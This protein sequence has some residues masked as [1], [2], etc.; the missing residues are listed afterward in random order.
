MRA[1]EYFQGILFLTT[2]RVE[3]FDPAFKSRIHLGLF[4][5]PLNA[6]SRR[7][8]WKNLLSRPEIKRDPLLLDSDLSSL[9]DGSGLNGRQIKNAVQIANAL[10]VGDGDPVSR[11][12]L[13]LAIGT[14]NAFDTEVD[15]STGKKPDEDPGDESDAASAMPARKRK[16]VESDG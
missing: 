6:S 7:Q 9:V 11:R 5:P 14:M 13:Q 4:Y 10:A 1:L 12:H 8:I 15:A 2:N 3:A 16:R